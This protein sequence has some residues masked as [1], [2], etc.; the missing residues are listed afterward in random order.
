[1]LL[2]AKNL[3]NLYEISYNDDETKEQSKEE[4]ELKCDGAA[5]ISS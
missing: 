3:V 2:P 1:M 4:E 5:S